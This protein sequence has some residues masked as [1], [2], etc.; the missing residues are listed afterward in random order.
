MIVWGG[1]LTVSIGG[2]FMAGIVPGLMI[3]LV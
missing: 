1:L 3:G 2:L